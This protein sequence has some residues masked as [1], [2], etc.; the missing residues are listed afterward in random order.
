MI[1]L[2][3]NFK[4]MFN[5][6]CI[7]NFLTLIILQLETVNLNVTKSYILVDVVGLLALV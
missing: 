5:V 6:F 7:S 2:N 1:S 4:S 3:R